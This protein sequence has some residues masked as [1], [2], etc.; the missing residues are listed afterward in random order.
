MFGTQNYGGGFTQQGGASYRP[1]QA[2]QQSAESLSLDDVMQGGAPSAFSKDDPIGTS[3]EGEIVEIRAEQ[4]TDF[5][6]G[7]PL[8]YPNGKPKP[9]VVIHL[10]TTM[11]DPNRIGDSG[12]RGV[13]VKGYNIGQLRL[14]CRQAGV[15]DHPNVGDH[16]KATFARTQP[17]KTRGFNDAKIY[18]YI[19]TPKKTADLT[20]AMNDPQAGMTQQQPAQPVQQV[21]FSQ[22]AGLTAQERQQVLQLKSLGKTPQEIAGLLG[23]TVDQVVNAVGAGSGQEPEF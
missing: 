11:T 18:D 22:P 8:Y 23:K 9:Q 19:V 13:Y 6:T 12:I 15:G 5:T 21:T 4:Q 14:A 20:T 3:V 10:Q 16:L 7:E 2:Q 1:Q 17:A